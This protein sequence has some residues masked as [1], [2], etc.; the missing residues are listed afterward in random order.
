MTRFSRVLLNNAARARSYSTAARSRA[1][2]PAAW[3]LGGVAV[4]GVAFVTLTPRS[5]VCE[6]KAELSPDQAVRARYGSAAD[7]AAAVKELQSIFSEDDIHVDDEERNH[8]GASQ[9]TYG[10]TLP[11]SAVVYPTST[12]DVA[13]ILKIATKYR[14]PVVPYGNG[15]SLE[16]QFSAVGDISGHS[17]RSLTAASAST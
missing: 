8:H 14:V 17:D 9:W 7:Y 16:G 2:H 5:T 4:A 1:A 3:F 12:E 11:P 15:T 10:I 6:P 13:K